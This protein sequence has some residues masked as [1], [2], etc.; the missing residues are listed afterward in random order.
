MAWKGVIRLCPIAMSRRAPHRAPQRTTNR[1][2][3]RKGRAPI[4]SPRVRACRID[5]QW[6][7][8]GTSLKKPVKKKREGGWQPKTQKKKKN[9]RRSQKTPTKMVGEY[10]KKKVPPLSPSHRQN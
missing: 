6:L 9:K 4:G 3:T 7:L 8:A 5:R 10:K 1:C 2:W